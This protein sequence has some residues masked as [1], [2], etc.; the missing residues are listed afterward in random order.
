MC[1]FKKISNGKNQN[2]RSSWILQSLTDWDY[3]YFVISHNLYACWTYCTAIFVYL[4]SR[5]KKFNIRWRKVAFQYLEK[6]K[7]NQWD[8]INK[9][10][11]SL[12]FFLHYKGKNNTREDDKDEEKWIKETNIYILAQWWQL[13][14]RWLP[15]KVLQS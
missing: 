1:A 15:L 13:P 11:Q 2:N 3:F 4:F 12:G 10:D 5:K 7:I 6:N 9:M 8:K 14:V